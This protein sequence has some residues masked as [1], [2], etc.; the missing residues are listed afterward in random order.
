MSELGFAPGD[1][2]AQLDV[3][4]KSHA[5][6]S[7]RLVERGV[8]S[9]KREGRGVVEHLTRFEVLEVGPADPNALRRLQHESPC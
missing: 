5:V 8:A 4:G 9:G 1:R 3:E 6:T 7:E 2:S